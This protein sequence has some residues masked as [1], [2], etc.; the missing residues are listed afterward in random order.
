MK[1][2][3]MMDKPKKTKGEKR[4]KKLKQPQSKPQPKIRLKETDTEFEE[5]K[6]TTEDKGKKFR[7][8]RT[9]EA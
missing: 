2:L 3:L 4:L 8:R 6:E 1:L 5:G 7:I 9:E